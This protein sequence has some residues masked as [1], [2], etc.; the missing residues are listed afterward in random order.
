M[1]SLRRPLI[2]ATSLLAFHCLAQSDAD[3]PGAGPDASTVVSLTPADDNQAANVS[4]IIPPLSAPTDSQAAQT[5][6]PPAGKKPDMAGGKPLPSPAPRPTTSAPDQFQRF[7]EAATGERLAHFGHELFDGP[8]STFAPLNDVPVPADY[9]IGPGDELL[10]RLSGAV[11]LDAQAS[12]DRNGQIRL[13]RIGT[14]PVTGVRVAEIEPYLREKIGRLYKNF[15]L[16]V[17]L[18]KLR[19]MQIYV[20]G[21]ARQPGAYVVSSMSTL[22]SALFASGGPSATGSMRHIKLL[23]KDRQISELDVYALINQGDKSADRPLQPGD[24]IVI[25]PAG[26]RVAL[27]GAYNR[28]AI[29]ELRQ[30]GETI[31][32]V[33]AYGG[34][35]PVTARPQTA[36]LE[37]IA[38]ERGGKRAVEE[39]N[40]A[41][42]ADRYLLKNGDMLSLLPISLG[43]DNAVTLRGHV[44]MPLRHPYRAEMRIRD[45]I[46]DAQTLL[47]A[48]YLQQKN[49]LVGYRH[50]YLSERDKPAD[51]PEQEAVHEQQRQ[52]QRG[53]EERQR[54][55]QQRLAAEINWDYAVIERLNPTTLT[56]ELLPFNLG[57]AVHQGDPAHDLVLKPGDV[58]TVFSKKDLGVPHGKDSHM[59]RLEGEVAVP[60]IYQALPGETLRELLVRIGG[61]SPDAY[62]LGARFFREGVRQ[63]QQRRWDESLNQLA[64]DVERIGSRKIQEASEASAVSAAAVNVESQRRLV[65]RLRAIRPEG[66]IIL[67]LPSEGTKIADLPDIPLEDGDRFEVPKTPPFVTVMGQVYSPGSFVFERDHRVADYLR[68]AGGPT[69]QANDDDIHVIHP[70][71][72]VTSS[73]QNGWLESGLEGRILSPGDT[74]FVP[75]ELDRFSW[76]KELKDWTAILYQ[77]GLGAAALKTITD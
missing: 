15:S 24:V 41:S 19:A 65:E 60:G 35:L 52:Q 72:T 30:D 68:L 39:I 71:G 61:L 47:T 10:V 8:P 18:G 42:G 27:L 37:R 32:E 21:Q 7:I 14:I 33:L 20:M 76:R 62:L 36:L 28:P 67:K 25:P 54:L 58:V 46:P 43:I 74:I 12:V 56:T 59:V 40:L 63:E 26:P 44:A 75:E 9:V 50:G 49:D 6:R 77:F 13:S 64:A 22:V 23:R 48:E 73:R 66:R 31:A 55:L 34:G 16:S 57:K 70:N 1:S 38:T 17:S 51:D 11:E 29:Y 4:V 2:L 3:M 45:L 69:A 5:G 53:Q